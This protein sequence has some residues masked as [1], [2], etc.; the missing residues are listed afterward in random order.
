MTEVWRPAVRWEGYYE[1]SDQGRVRSLDR[2][3]SARTALG[4]EYSYFKRGRVLRGGLA[5]EK[6]YPQVRLMAD[7]RHEFAYVHRLVL[8]SFTGPPPEGAECCHLDDD[9]QNNHL[10]NL[11][12]DTHRNNA[13]DITRN[14]NSH[15]ANKTHCKYGHEFSAENT[16]TPPNARTAI[17]HCRT[18]RKQDDRLRYL[19][20]KQS[21]TIKGVAA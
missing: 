8:E 18:C 20:R 19:R 13:F 11:R 9:P 21:K 17:R 2:L 12:W 5:T 10:S 7:G 6:L 1:V 3:V 14:G 16:Y 15:H 4:K